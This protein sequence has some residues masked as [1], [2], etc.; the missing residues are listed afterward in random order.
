MREDGTRV[1]AKNK[2]INPVGIKT[3]L[4]P[5][6][7]PKKTKAIIET[8]LRSL[9]TH[10]WAATP[11]QG[12][13]RRGQRYQRDPWG[14]SVTEGDGVGRPGGKAG[15]IISTTEIG[16]PLD[17]AEARRTT[18]SMCASYVGAKTGTPYARRMKGGD[19]GLRNAGYFWRCIARL[20]SVARVGVIL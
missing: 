13:A 5:D 9:R 15:I 11:T 4:S 3:K 2:D 14:V 12:H 6:R 10:V 1:L 16:Q 7:R 18:R 17:A 19:V 20:E 8:E